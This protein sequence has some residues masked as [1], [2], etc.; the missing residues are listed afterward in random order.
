MKSTWKLR[1]KGIKKSIF[2][3]YIYIYIFFFKFL[4]GFLS[5]KAGECWLLPLH[6]QLSFGLFSNTFF[7][8]KS[9]K[10]FF[11]FKYKIKLKKEHNIHALQPRVGWLNTCRYIIFYYRLNLG[12][13][14]AAKQRKKR[15][16]SGTSISI[17]A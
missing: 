14:R 9:Q 6:C 11:F 4:V 1:K 3:S 8:F 10:E 12:W 2:K 17:G 15:L 13:K 7:N 16:I 5:E